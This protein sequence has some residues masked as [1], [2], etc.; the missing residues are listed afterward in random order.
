M[1]DKLPEFSDLFLGIIELKKIYDAFT[2]DKFLS[3]TCS[4]SEA[5]I[6]RFD[7]YKKDLVSLKTYVKDYFPNL[8]EKIFEDT[9]LENN[10]VAYTGFNIKNHIR[11][12]KAN[13]LK[14]C[15]QAK[16]FSFLKKE[17][18]LEKKEHEEDSNYRRIKQG[19]E[20]GEF[21]KKLKNKENGIFP[22]Q[23]HEFELVKILDSQRKY[24]SFLDE[25][26]SEGFSNYEKIISIFKFKVPYFVGP[27]I[28]SNDE[29]KRKFAWAKLI[30][31]NK[32]TKIYPWNFSKV[33]DLDSSAEEFI[34][35][36]QNKCT[37]LHDEY[38][39]PKSSIILSYFN[40][41]NFLNTL[42]I[43]GSRNTLKIDDRNEIIKNLFLK[44][45]NV[46][47]KDI[48]NY[49]NNKYS[50]EVEID[51]EEKSSIN[52]NMNSY[53][54]LANIF[55]D[56]YI[57]D[58]IDLIEDL[59]TDIT[60]FEDKKI[61]ENRLKT[62]YKFD[63]EIINKIRAIKFKDFG[64]LSKKLLVGIKDSKNKS[65]LNYMIDEKLEFNEILN[66][67]EFNDLIND[68]N[69]KN[70]KSSENVDDFIGDL[71][72]PKMAHRAIKQVYL[73]IKE[74][75]K[76]IGNRKISKY[77]I[78]FTRSN[79]DKNKG[80]NSTS[81][82]DSIKELLDSCK[83]EEFKEIKEK[84]KKE[85]EP[86]KDKLKSEKYFL[87][88]AQLGKS[89]YSGEKID[90][91]DLKNGDLYDVDHIYPRA[92]VKDDSL[93]NNKVLVEKSLN[94][95]KGDTYPIDTSILWKNKGGVKAAYK[96]FDFLH[97]RDKKFMNSE[98]LSRLKKQD[99]NE[100]ELDHFVNRQKVITD[101]STMGIVCLLKDFL[102]VDKENFVYSKGE[103]VSTFRNTYELIKSRT[104]NNF[105]HAH[106]AYLNIVVGNIFDK[107]FKG[108]FIKNY[109][110]L[111]YFKEKSIS[112]N[113]DYLMKKDY[114]YDHNGEV[115]WDKKEQLNK[116][117]KYL[118]HTN[119][120]MVTER[121]YVGTAL[122]S[123]SSMVRGT[124]VV[125]LKKGIPFEKEESD[126]FKYGGY[127]DPSY[128][129]Y[130]L[131]EIENKK[132]QKEAFLVANSDLLP[133]KEGKYLIKKL[134]I[135]TVIE[136][137]D[138]KYSIS[139][140]SANTYVLKNKA[141]RFFSY[142]NLKIIKKIDKF[143]EKISNNK[144]MNIEDTNSLDSVFKI[145]DNEICIYKTRLGEV[146]TLSEGE[147][148]VLYDSIIDIF[149][150]RIYSFSVIKKIKDLL[151][152][153]RDFFK[154]LPIYKKIFIISQLLNLLK[155]NERKAANLKY[156][157]SSE[158]SG[159]L[160]VNQKMHSGQRIVYESVTGFYKKIIWDYN[161][162]HSGLS[163]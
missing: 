68:Y 34:T 35:R 107:Y 79:K 127:S 112:A 94:N 159:V 73:I 125:P 153:K 59:I 54:V 116:I 28:F 133:V 17:L 30:D 152:S 77:F 23:L 160:T 24:W 100:T 13:G 22:N 8:K 21:L 74:I 2:L 136:D 142:E 53:I 97:E 96:F 154:S 4:I 50:C 62:I 93:L 111:K 114:L 139:G 33:V 108:R 11:V 70:F 18:D 102:H 63:Y 88:F 103:N 123:K 71:Y 47:W 3:G 76:I 135:N 106:D 78:E 83:E 41:L 64:R 131:M 10:Y 14:T 20:S 143:I 58:N 32:H 36:M 120:I 44:K 26:D 27:L 138:L 31:S 146:L 84:F 82:Y 49:F 151:L 38:C 145:S 9:T 56:N 162:W 124:K 66:Q 147:I 121:C 98:K 16:L 132:G 92:L 129:F 119:D 39:L 42:S 158:N 37:Y 137:G 43:N 65:I 80:K 90:F 87:Y 67:F 60:I 105:H 1:V 75:Q 122:F 19:I 91:D 5:M 52:V 7:E 141:E 155:T 128:N 29:E 140:K 55:G 117:K 46:N 109:S 45:K 85:I 113:V 40:A 25:I 15:D 69:S 161:K 110:D 89:L 51:K 149:G 48:K 86:D 72:I 12:N 95:L 101:Q 6:R 99:F 130:S 144:T 81:R 57:K 118:Y 134:K 104:A 150:K 156:L 115:I 163:Q 148:Y 157:E 126:V 61:L